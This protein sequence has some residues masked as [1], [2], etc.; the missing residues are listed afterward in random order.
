MQRASREAKSFDEQGSRATMPYHS[1]SRSNTVSLSNKDAF[2]PTTLCNSHDDASEATSPVTLL[3]HLHGN[4]SVERDYDG[5]ETN[6]RLQEMHVL[7]SSDAEEGKAMPASLGQLRR[8]H[9]PDG[10]QD[11]GQTSD[12]IAKAEQP[13][14]VTRNAIGV[15]ERA[16]L[17][18]LPAGFHGT[19]EDDGPPSYNLASILK[20]SSDWGKD[21]EFVEG[22]FHEYPFL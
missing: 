9:L 22:I 6:A 2:S 4:R 7:P 5:S 3:R 14:T 13:E 1:G 20:G 11:G 12:G 19:D 10:L 16:T 15:Q 8:M 21:L 17:Q 18:Q